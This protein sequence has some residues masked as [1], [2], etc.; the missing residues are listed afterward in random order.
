MH[1]RHKWKLA[2]VLPGYYKG[3]Y[4]D[5]GHFTWLLYQCGVCPEAKVE[6]IPGHW[7]LEDFKKKEAE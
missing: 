6:Q 1:L 2:A 7:K 5:G 3:G 4:Q